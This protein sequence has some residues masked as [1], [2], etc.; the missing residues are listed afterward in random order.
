MGF[1]LAGPTGYIL[2]VSIRCRLGRW[3]DVG[4]DGGIKVDAPII[5]YVVRI[6]T[7]DTCVAEIRTSRAT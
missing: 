3:L 6:I 1:E 5:V 4:E 2:A 7:A